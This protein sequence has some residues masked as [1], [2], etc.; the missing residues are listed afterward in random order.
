MKGLDGSN[1]PLSTIQS[2]SFCIFRRIARNPRVCVRFAIAR[3]PR[4]RLL[5]RHSPPLLS[6][7]RSSPRPET[8][9][10]PLKSC[11]QNRGDPIAQCFKPET[12]SGGIG[13]PMPRLWRRLTCRVFAYVLSR[14][15]PSENLHRNPGLRFSWLYAFSWS[16]SALA[17]F[18]SAVSKPSVNQP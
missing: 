7:V 5:Q 8:S 1:L 10:I 6:F 18:R 17:S 16:S 12:V 13:A 15:G 9:P 3:G 4:E 2:I 14:D 11:W